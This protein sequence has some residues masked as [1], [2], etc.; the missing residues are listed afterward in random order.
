MGELG[1]RGVAF[2]DANP[3]KHGTEI[4]GREVLPVEELGAVEFDLLLVAVLSDSE[5]IRDRLRAAGLEEGRDFAL[6]F[7]SGKR[8]QVLDSL[9][10]TLSF[11]ERF[12]LTGREAVEVGFGGQLFLAL[13]LLHRGVSRVV[14][15]DVEAQLGAL[16]R[17]EGEWRSF[18]ADLARA[19]PGRARDEEPGRI[20]ER[21][22]IHSTPTRAEDLPFDDASFDLVANT[23]VME[24]V[25]DPGGAIDAFARV[26][27][28]G[29]LAL[30][31][32][33]GIHDH[34]ANDPAAPFTPWSF[35]VSTEDE[36]RELGRSAYHQNRWRAV[37]F[38]RA[39]EERGFDLLARDCIVDP[40]LGPAEARRFAEPFRSG[41]SL[42]QLAELDLDLGARL[43]SG[44]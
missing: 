37:D 15:T 8:L 21:I 3:T 29:G 34:R 5:G 40:R 22:E 13:T 4:A 28:P 32:A 44:G 25:D 9:P 33:V 16:E 17:R 43:R 23:G 7:P 10:R 42:T 30:C 1:D 41:Y 2:L 11:L 6:P 18:L 12:D 31:L 39:F 24:H 26:L 35:L 36:W 14:V 20:L 19:A 38:E 27:R